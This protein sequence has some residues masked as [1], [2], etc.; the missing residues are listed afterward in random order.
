MNVVSHLT[1]RQCGL[2]VFTWNRFFLKIK[3]VWKTKTSKG[4]V[5]K[6]L[7][8]IKLGLSLGQ[9]QNLS[10]AFVLCMQIFLPM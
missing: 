10:L 2:E 7:T 5:I 6:T 9:G 1:L 8:L 3:G 4:P